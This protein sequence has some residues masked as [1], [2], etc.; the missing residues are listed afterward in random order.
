MKMDE[1]KTRYHLEQPLPEDLTL[2]ELQAFK[3]GPKSFSIEKVSEHI[4]KAGVIPIQWTEERID[5]YLA[6]IEYIRVR[7]LLKGKEVIDGPFRFL[8]GNTAFAVLEDSEGERFQHPKFLKRIH[9]G[10]LV[11]SSTAVWIWC[12]RCLCEYRDG[13]KDL[14]VTC[15]CAE[16][17]QLPFCFRCGAGSSIHQDNQI[18]ARETEEQENS[19]SLEDVLSEDVCLCKELF[20][21]S[22][23][24]FCGFCQRTKD[25]G[26]STEGTEA[27]DDSHREREGKREADGGA[28]VY[29]AGPTVEQK[30]A[31][32]QPKPRKVRRVSDKDMDI[33]LTVGIPGQDIDGVTFDRLALYVEQKARMGIIAMERGDS[34]LQLHMQGMLSVR[35]N[36]THSLKTEIR[37]A[38]SWGEKEPAGG[39]ICVKSL[40]DKGIHTV[41]GMIG[42]CLKDEREEHYRKYTKNITEQQMEDGRAEAFHLRSLSV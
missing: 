5:W 37:E 28:D 23:A 7:K 30:E 27:A 9:D 13:S 4:G 3:G 32:R 39:S 11:F 35:A 38:I 6:R 15:F 21:S 31:T 2:G 34:H 36:N 8:E 42:Y 16:I 1:S 17:F 41:I 10:K 14:P 19:E 26:R 20:Q 40:K 25:E 22:N 33:S 18:D 12:S 29:K 24:C